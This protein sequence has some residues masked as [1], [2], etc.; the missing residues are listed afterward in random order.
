MSS[1]YATLTLRLLVIL[2]CLLTPL[3][4]TIAEQVGAIEGYANFETLRVQLERIARSPLAKLSTLGRT[5]EG[6]EVFLLT[7]GKGKVDNRPGILVL[8]GVDATQLIGS[9]LAVRM[10][11][12]LVERAANDKETAQLLEQVTFYVIP[13][14][15]PDACESFFVKPTG[16]RTTNSRPTDDDNDGRVDEDGPNDLSGDGWITAMR[17]QEPTGQY[18]VHPADPRVM[19]LAD[20]KKGE[21]GQWSLHVEGIDD[22]GDG[23]L[24]EDPVGGVAFDRNFT[25]GY[26][27]FKP[28]AGPHQVSEPETKAVADF[29]F[30]RRNM[31]VVMTFSA[32]DNLFHVPKGESSEKQGKIKTKLL[33]ADLPYLERMAK[34]YR[35]LHGGTGAPASPKGNGCVSDWAYF[36]YGRWSLAA[37]PWWITAS[38]SGK[39][40]VATGTDTTSEKTDAE[41]TAEVKGANESSAERPA[42]DKADDDERGRDDL[43]ALAWF[44]KKSINGFVP[45]KPIEHPDFPNRQVEV[46]GFKPYL[47]ENPP[48]SEIKGLDVKH[49]DFLCR[50]A[51]MLP[52]LKIA[53][54]KAE[55]LGDG[56]WRVEATVVNQG[57]LPTFPEMGE[58]SQQIQPVQIAIDLPD[59]ASLVTGYARRR[60]PTLA[61]NGGHAKETWLARMPADTAGKARVRVWSPSVGSTKRTIPLGGP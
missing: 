16:E 13:R 25:F 26:P 54:L 42:K 19:I 56:V 38:D 58:I 9:E 61:G 11:R 60:L 29:A 30:G 43:H 55:S 18:T 3:A 50:V 45:W 7:I 24:N 14:A 59:V 2:A 46:G 20:P 21:R 52:R 51:G 35:E 6:R 12:R 27:Y 36:H 17:V 39:P 4:A 33:E 53:E 15:S 48:L 22:D 1:R 40:N 28:G 8:G 57:E 47:R 49:V 23:Q 34:L 44:D 5:R 37:Q 41:G 32:Q 10:A 31:S